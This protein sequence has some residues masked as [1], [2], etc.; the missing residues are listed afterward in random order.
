[1]LFQCSKIDIQKTNF[2][3]VVEFISN[4]C[5]IITICLY[6]FIS[7]MVIVAP[8]VLKIQWNISNNPRARIGTTHMKQIDDIK[9]HS[10]NLCD[11]YYYSS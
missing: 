3:N 5:Q 8:I 2:A 4:F 1:M 6:I 11:P 10:N 9:P 7:S